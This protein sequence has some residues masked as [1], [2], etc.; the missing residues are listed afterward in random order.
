MHAV[1]NTQ[2][3]LLNPNH[4]NLQDPVRRCTCDLAE[5]VATSSDE[6]KEEPI[7]TVISKV[8]DKGDKSPPIHGDVEEW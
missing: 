2:E 1:T 6:D 8:K 3:E 5:D 4:I 7:H